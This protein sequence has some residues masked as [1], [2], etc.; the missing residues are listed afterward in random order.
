[1]SVWKSID[2]AST[3]SEGFISCSFDVSEDSVNLSQ[4]NAELNKVP[5]GVT[6][7]EFQ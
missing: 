5:D 7:K 6:V 2:C 3:V 4:H 1:M